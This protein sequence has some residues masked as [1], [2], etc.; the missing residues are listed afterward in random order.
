MNRDFTFRIIKRSG[1]YYMR[2]VDVITKDVI[3]EKSLRMV[4]KELGIK[5]DGIA[6]G[7]NKDKRAE[8]IAF[9][10]QQESKDRRLDCPTVIEY[11]RSYWDFDG[12]RVTLANRKNPNSVAKSS[13]YTNLNN[14]DNHIAAYF[15]DNPRI[16][17]ITSRRL[18]GIQDDLLM[19]GKLSNATIEKI[20]RSVTTPLNDAFDHGLID[21]GVRVD[22]L[23]TKGKEK[24]IL[25]DTQIAAVVKQLYIMGK[26]S[27][28][29]RGANEGISLAALTAMRMGEI[30]A[31][32]TDQ[33][34]VIDDVS[35]IHITRAWNN[36]D[37]EKI[38][39]G[40]RERQVTV[41]T[42]IAK[43]LLELAE[44]NPWK[45]GRVFWTE[46]SGDTVKSASFFRNNFYEAMRRAGIDEQT[47]S[48]KNITF[49][50]LRHG[51]VSYLRHQVSDSTMRLAIG[52]RDKETTDEYTHLN[53][54]NMRQL[55]DSTKKTFEAVITAETEIMQENA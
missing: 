43:A 41:P 23:N 8:E 28:G 32:K 39:K 14:F 2:L 40:K 21:N 48:D 13:C 17:D 5:F 6:G 25:T 18:N 53:I 36:H 9:M 37:H 11:C 27:E 4:A 30:R 3:G 34:E 16:N 15:P 22:A 51:Y 31:L 20:M 1:R 50:S 55:A 7:R 44:A 49:H 29:K 35:I 42:V 46:K 12:E 52:H 54:D 19:K 45:N 33:I 38:P 47:R 26:E 24:G 10:Y